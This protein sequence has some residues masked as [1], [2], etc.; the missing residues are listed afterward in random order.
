MHNIGSKV[1]LEIAATL[2]IVCLGTI[3]LAVKDFKAYREKR[4]NISN[5]N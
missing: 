5:S 2:L 3:N 1:I 4:R